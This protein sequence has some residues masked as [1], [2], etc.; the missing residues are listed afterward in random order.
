ML[1]SINALLL[2]A[3]VIGTFYLGCTVV[4]LVRFTRRPTPLATEFLPSVTILK[5]IAGREAGLYEN[6]ASFCNQDYG[7]LYDVVFCL[8]DESDPALPVVELVVRDFPGCRTQIVFGENPDLLNPKVA[9]LA[10][11]GVVTTRDVIVI[12]DSDVSVGPTLLRALAASFESEAVGAVTCLYRAVPNPTFVSRLGALGINDGFAPSVLVALALG[13]LRFC[14]GATMAV[15]GTVLAT[16]GGLSALGRTL[17]DDHM[18]GQLVTNVG[19]K[20]ELSRYVVA[21]AVPE[22]KLKKLFSHELRWARTDFALARAGY[23]FSFL[24]YA[25]PLALLYLIVSRNLVLGLPL[26][27]VVCGL[28]YAVHRLSRYALAI[29]GR[30][31][32][33]L[34]PLRDLLSVAV[35]ATSLVGKRKHF[36]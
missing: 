7:G 13:E 34:I 14:L 5:P 4:Q 9:N 19:Y 28:R 27:A 15:R 22:K 32:A 12:A 26:L 3:A 21:T 20:V 8:H 33:A 6:L 2:V 29:E 11:S 16:I 24:I 35:W 18:L 23:L 31:D 30:D 25:L 1:L 10:K 17:A 36:R